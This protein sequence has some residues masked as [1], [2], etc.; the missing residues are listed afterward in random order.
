MSSRDPDKKPKTARVS[1]AREF[2]LVDP[3][4]QTDFDPK[5]FPIAKG[6]A[7]LTPEI[8]DP[9]E[10]ITF[11]FCT[12]YYELNRLYASSKEAREQEQSPERNVQER[13][14][15]Q[16][17]EKY[18]RIRD[19]LEDR[20]APYGVIAEAITQDG[21]TTD[22]IFT[23]GNR[24]AASQRQTPFVSSSA[25]LIFPRPSRFGPRTDGGNH[26]SRS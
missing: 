12:V 18:L 11:E 2:L 22:I 5:L 17:I 6:T 16:E 3:R 7:V 14:L 24:S 1:I 10:R 13:A 8:K 23:F 21:F 15:A 9:N 4:S 19:E 20:Y 26:E 25:L